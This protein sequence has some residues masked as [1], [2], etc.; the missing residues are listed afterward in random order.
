[1][2]DSK[3]GKPEQGFAA[4]C[5]IRHERLAAV[6]VQAAEC[7]GDLGRLS[8]RMNHL[9]DRVTGLGDSHRATIAALESNTAAMIAATETQGR[10]TVSLDELKRELSQIREAVHHDR[11][12]FAEHVADGERDKRS[13]PRIAISLWLM[14]LSLG[15]IAIY[16]VAHNWQWLVHAAAAFDTTPG[17]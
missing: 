11:V 5:G 15:G 1:M 4:G 6:E 2:Q 9:E 8:E 17:G 12:Y 10:L 3:A 7:R 16:F 14:G 13:A